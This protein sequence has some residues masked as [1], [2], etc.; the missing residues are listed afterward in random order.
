MVKLIGWYLP[1]RKENHGRGC[2]EVRSL[3][4]VGISC[5]G[6]YTVLGG[7]SRFYM[8]PQNPFCGRKNLCVGRYG[9]AALPVKTTPLLWQKKKAGLSPAL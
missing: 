4:A 2:G 9:A 5:R 1:H 7:V 6:R 8:C 3:R